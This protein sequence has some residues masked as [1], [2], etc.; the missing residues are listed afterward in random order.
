MKTKLSILAIIVC[1]SAAPAMAD[2]F[3]FSVHN[4]V[5]TWD[6]TDTLSVSWGSNTELTLSRDEPPTGTVHLGSST[7]GDFSMLL[8]VSVIDATHADAVGTFTITDIDP[9]ADTI[10][11][12]ITGSFLRVGGTNILVSELSNLA[13]NDNGIGDGLFNADDG[14]LSMSFG[15]P[16]SIWDGTLSYTMGGSPWFGDSRW[17]VDTGS[18]DA[19]VLPVP[20]GVILGLLGLGVAGWKMRRFA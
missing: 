11:G 20:A 13:F 10:T 4:P 2:L 19:V 6:G 3:D 16:Q 14:S 15:A 17:S 5:G 18:V 7:L 8:T 1:M 9:I 12:V